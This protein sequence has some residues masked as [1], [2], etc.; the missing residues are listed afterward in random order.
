M[1]ILRVSRPPS[2][3]A[4]SGP[5][6]HR[7]PGAFNAESRVVLSILDVAIPG[8]SPPASGGF[9][10]VSVDANLLCE[11]HMHLA[12]SWLAL[13]REHDEFAR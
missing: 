7:I 9:A 2:G 12:T 1:F 6:T 8:S 13:D 3:L 4:P 10:A 11:C 5:S